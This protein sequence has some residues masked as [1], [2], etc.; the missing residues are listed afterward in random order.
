MSLQKFNFDN[1]NVRVI[2]KDGNPWF[3]AKDICSVL[4]LSNVS[5]SLA[6]LDDDERGI[7]SNDT[8]EEQSF[9]KYTILIIFFA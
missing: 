7:I 3:V 8:I 2:L 4:G 5:Q 9:T 1:N 6:I